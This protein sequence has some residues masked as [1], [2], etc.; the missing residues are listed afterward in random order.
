[1]CC[2]DNQGIVRISNIAIISSNLLTSLMHFENT[3]FTRTCQH[4]VFW[5]V[6]FWAVVFLVLV[7]IFNTSGSFQKIDLI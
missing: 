6:V 4:M 3:K 1:M 7:N 5:A 2:A